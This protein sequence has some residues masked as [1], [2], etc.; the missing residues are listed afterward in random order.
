MM[1]TSIN[2]I[3]AVALAQSTSASTAS[4]STVG[5]APTVST[6]AGENTGSA[7]EI[8]RNRKFAE[9]EE[10]TDAKLKADTGSLSKYSLKFNLSYY[11]PMVGD[12]SAKD[13]PNPDGSISPHATAISGSFGGRYRLSSSSSV[14]MGTGM[15]A[16]HPFHGM[17]RFD[18]ND[19]FLG[20]DKLYRIGDVQM[21][22][23]PS[24]SYIT[25]PEYKKAGE[26]AGVSY[27]T[28][29]IYNLGT[30]HV[31]LGVDASV[32]YYLYGRG[33]RSSDRSA[34]QYT[35]STFPTL[36]YNISDRLNI[37]TSIKMAWA[38]FR[39]SKDK[40][41][42]IP[43]TTTQRLGVGYALT[44]DIYLFPYLN[45]YPNSFT[46]DSTTL[47]LSTSFSIL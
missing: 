34:N 12:L 6:S 46:Q 2:L 7:R 41:Q 35:L 11:G 40:Y 13:Q 17:D 14:S 1:A 39:R 18:V 19:P 25:T 9:D 31:A 33:Y 20:Y 43:Q 16:N 38:N 44:R 45:F 5:A 47:N 10:I 36:K 37:N 42:M 4:V 15:K 23:S 22:L 30:S 24:V 3:A 8:L 32:G 28:S 27:D 29:L 21:R 26:F